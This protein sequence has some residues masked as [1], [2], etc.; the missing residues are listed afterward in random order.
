MQ[1]RD[2]FEIT[3]IGDRFSVVDRTVA[4]GRTVS[5]NDTAADAQQAFE[6][7][8]VVPAEWLQVPLLEEL[9][10]AVARHA[11]VNYATA[12]TA[13]E[14]LGEDQVWALADDFLDLL[15]AATHLADE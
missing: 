15:A 4:P 7:A 1:I 14:T 2:H 6:K 5:V 8:S 9:A 3:K 11:G 12:V 13:P 10:D